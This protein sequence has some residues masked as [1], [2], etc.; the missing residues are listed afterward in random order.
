MVQ[1]LFFEKIESNIEKEIPDDIE[2]YINK[3]IFNDFSVRSSF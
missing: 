1:I 3:P 2:E